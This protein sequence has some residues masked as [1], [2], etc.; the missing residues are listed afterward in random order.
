MYLPQKTKA[1]SNFLVVIILKWSVGFSLSR[2]SLCYAAIKPII[3]A[4]AQWYIF[5]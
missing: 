1:V 5:E 3:T 2:H 4:K